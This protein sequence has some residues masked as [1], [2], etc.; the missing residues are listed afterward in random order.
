MAMGVKK[1]GQQAVGPT[2]DLAAHPLDADSVVG[3]AGERPALV[4]PP[5]DQRASGLAVGVRAALRYGERAALG[6]NCGDV[7]F[8]GTEEWLYND[9]E[10]GTPPLVVRPAK[11][12]ATT[13]GVVLSAQSACHY[14]RLCRFRQA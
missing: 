11:H 1:V 6:E 2:A 14:P 5:A 10:L 9:H 8:D 3:F 13:G 12:R 4:G 7:F